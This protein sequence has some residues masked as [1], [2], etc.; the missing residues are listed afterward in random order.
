MNIFI[1]LK[2]IKVF[3]KKF[4]KIEIIMKENKKCVFKTFQ[5]TII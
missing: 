1:S 3:I 4:L 5:R 2:I